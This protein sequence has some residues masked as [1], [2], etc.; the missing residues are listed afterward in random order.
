MQECGSF[1]IFVGVSAYGMFGILKRYE[2]F[3]KVWNFE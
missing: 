3:W 2:C 1:E